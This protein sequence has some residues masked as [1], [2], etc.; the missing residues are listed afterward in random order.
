MGVASI[1][2]KMAYS[3]VGDFKMAMNSSN[4]SCSFRDCSFMAWIKV[5]NS[6]TPT[7]DRAEYTEEEACVCMAWMRRRLIVKCG[8]SYW[9][10]VYACEFKV[11]KIVI[12]NKLFE[13]TDSPTSSNAV[14]GVNS[15][16]RS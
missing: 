12:G 14:E 10:V 5:S 16:A 8:S 13:I 4:S 7:A 6:S 11:L 1:V 15:S 9:G 2:K 3:S